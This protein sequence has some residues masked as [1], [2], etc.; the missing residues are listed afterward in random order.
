MFAHEQRLHQPC[1]PCGTSHTR[2]ITY[3]ITS[4]K[5]IRK[6]IL[7]GSRYDIGDTAKTEEWV[8][9]ISLPHEV[10]FFAYEIVC[11]WDETCEAVDIFIDGHFFVQ[12][13]FLFWSAELV[14]ITT[15]HFEE[16][17]PS[18]INLNNKKCHYPSIV[19]QSHA[20]YVLQSVRNFWNIGVWYWCNI[21]WFTVTSSKDVK[22]NFAGKKNAQSQYSIDV[23]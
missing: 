9:P 21:K 8:T 12:Y 19:Q 10:V 11:I 15:N 13:H 3:H 17:Y 14:Y 2:M 20:F 16:Y 6:S 23:S 4:P 22:F 5:E 18:A 7:K 1:A